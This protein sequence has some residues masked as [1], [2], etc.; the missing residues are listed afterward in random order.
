ML[1]RN[2]VMFPVCADSDKEKRFKS[3][4][5]GVSAEDKHIFNLFLYRVLKNEFI[6]I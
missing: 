6:F 2:H 4:Q 3:Y 1:A 5:P